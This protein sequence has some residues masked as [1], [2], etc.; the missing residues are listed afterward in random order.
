MLRWLLL[1]GIAAPISLLFD[2]L[3]VP[4]SWPLGILTVPL[5]M[6]FAALRFHLLDLDLVVDRTLV[7]LGSTVFIVGCFVG[8]LWLASA[9]VGTTQPA[10]T[11]LEVALAKVTAPLELSNISV[12]TRLTSSVRR[13]VLLREMAVLHRQP[14]NMRR[15]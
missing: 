8:L 4:G 6:L 5:V 9:A 1:L 10:I 3:R 13:L 2:A 7:W 12:G 14:K 15:R 11:G